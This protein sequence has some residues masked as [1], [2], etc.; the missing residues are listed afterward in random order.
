MACQREI[1]RRSE[2]QGGLRLPPQVAPHEGVGTMGRRF[3]PPPGQGGGL[4]GRKWRHPSVLALVGT[5]GRG[6]DPVAAVRAEAQ[7]FVA[8]ARGIGWSGPPFDPTVL[9][10]L[11]GI[12]LRE[13]PKDMTANA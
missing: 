10:S 11:R 1:S 13:G 12:T 7:S 3:T 4:L 6:R 2:E 9:A 8:W 5:Q